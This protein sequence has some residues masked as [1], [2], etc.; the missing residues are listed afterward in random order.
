MAFTIVVK[1]PAVQAYVYLL[2]IK[3]EM[4]EHWAVFKIWTIFL[5]HE[6]HQFTFCEQKYKHV[7][8]IA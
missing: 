4:F 2:G 3:L 6:S 7:I 1:T 8:I 5:F